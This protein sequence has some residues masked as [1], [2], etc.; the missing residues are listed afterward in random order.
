MSEGRHVRARM[1]VAF[2]P[3]GGGPWPFVD[4]GFPAAE[5]ESLRTYLRELPSVPK[6]TP[7]AIL[8]VSAHWEEAAPTVTTSEA[9]PMLYDYYGFPDAAYSIQWPAPGAPALAARV[10]ELLGAAGI[11]AASDPK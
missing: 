5:V 4:L 3:H 8:V 1:P 7:K 11:A 2:I 9:P 10:R 6:T